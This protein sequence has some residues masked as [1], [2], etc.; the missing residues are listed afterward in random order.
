ML[1]QDV[2]RRTGLDRATIRFYEKEGI[3]VPMREENGYRM[4]QEHDIALLLK[5]KLL[6]QLGV[7][8]STIKSL[9]QGN[10]DFSVVLAEQ[11]VYLERP[12]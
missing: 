9:Q 5:I 1:I 6:R 10:S 4:Y 12:R 2:E 11:I 8:L 7:S 3:V